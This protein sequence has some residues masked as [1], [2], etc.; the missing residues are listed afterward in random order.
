[1][2]SSPQRWQRPS[3]VGGIHAGGTRA[4]CFMGMVDGTKWQLRVVRC[5]CTVG[6]GQESYKGRPPVKAPDC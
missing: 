3:K 6:Y 4:C 2:W 1:M 5:I